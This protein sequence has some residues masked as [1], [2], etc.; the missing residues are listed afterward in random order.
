MISRLRLLVVAVA[1]ATA[2]TSAATQ[3]VD[4]PS[5]DLFG[6]LEAYAEAE[7]TERWSDMLKAA[8][9]LSQ[10]D[11]QHPG[12]RI[13]F[14]RANARVGH[15]EAALAELAW[16]AEQGFGYSI[17]EDQAFARI[18]S[19][20][21][22]IRSAKKMAANNQP[23]GIQV[24]Q[25]IALDRPG[26]VPEGF[27]HDVARQRWILG[28]LATP[29]V[30]SVSYDGEVSVLWTDPRPDRQ[31]LGLSISQDRNAVYVCS[32]RRV[33]DNVGLMPELIKIDL[34]S[35]L[36]SASIPLPI[37]DGLCND[38]IEVEGGLVAV[39]DS[40]AGKV[41]L[42]NKDFTQANHVGFGHQLYYPNGIAFLDGKL[43]VADV[44]G[45]S[46]YRL[47]DRRSYRLRPNRTLAGI[48][49]LHVCGGALAAVQNLVQPARIVTLAPRRN[50]AHVEVRVSARPELDDMTALA[51]REG[52]AIV[53]TRTGVANFTNGD[54]DD[55]A[56]RP[57]LVALERGKLPC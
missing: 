15:M 8:T 31:T 48:D 17:M 51:I 40:N 27:T 23:S 1:L 10:I 28:S 29:S 34:Q 33:S 56:S 12:F 22:F 53:L 13:R 32:N 47:R 5:V 14:A 24:V 52:Q 4:T 42:I 25:A 50:D 54:Q 18:R 44:L 55:L 3:D 9:A 37:Q 20:P 36:K 39:T 6:L 30:Y 49:G 21:R 7:R 41:W 19:N 16:L 26:L 45:V 2:P 35:G 38:A 43:F 57:A 11:R 46:A